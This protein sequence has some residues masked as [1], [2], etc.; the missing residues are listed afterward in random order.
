MDSLTNTGALIEQIRQGNRDA[1]RI[2]VD[3]NKRLVSH[4]IYRAAGQIPD[5]EDLC[6]DVFLKVYR[7]IHKFR[8]DAKLSTW[9]A[10]IAY[11]TSINYLRKKR[12]SL[13]ED[14][15]RI[16]E[17]TE[18]DED[19]P[20][21]QTEKRDIHQRI[22]EAIDRLPI[23]MKTVITLYHLEEMNYKEIGEIMKLP[24]GTMKSYLFRARRHL[25]KIL[26]H[27]LEPK[28]VQL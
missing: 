25:K 20:D 18:T 9:I 19:L 28:D 6:Q 16:L 5:H 12:P 24:E 3:Q 2:L 8:E 13:Y 11:N 17:T 27:Q 7:N 1:F 15:T 23:Q 26:S 22:A 21:I 4:V 10:Q 14:E